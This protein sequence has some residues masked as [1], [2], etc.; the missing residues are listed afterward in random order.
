MIAELCESI[1][2]DAVRLTRAQAAELDRRLG[3]LDAEPGEGRDA[4]EALADLRRGHA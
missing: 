4:F 3:M 2:H 1:D